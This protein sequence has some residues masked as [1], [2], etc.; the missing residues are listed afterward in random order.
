MLA[1]QAAGDAAKCMPTGNG[2]ASSKDVLVRPWGNPLPGAD[3]KAA[4]A[5]GFASKLRL[6]RAVPVILFAALLTTAMAGQAQAAP[7]QTQ[8]ATVPATSGAGQA[9]GLLGLPPSNDPGVQKAQQLLEKMVAAL[10][11]QAYLNIQDMQQQGRTYSFYHGEPEGTGAPFWRFWK[12]PDKDRLELTKQRDWV[13]VFNG[14]KGYETTFR[15][16]APV[17]AEQLDDY[18]RRR[19]HS[20]AWVLRKWL[21]QPGVA[22]FYEGPG[23]AE[24][25]QAE[26]VSVMTVDNDA[27]TIS[28]DS[29]TFLPLRVAFTWRDPKTR[30]RNDEAEGYDNYRPIQGVMSPF[31]IIRYH[32][33]EPANQR[34]INMVS[35]NQNLPDSQFAAKVTWDPNKAPTK[36][37]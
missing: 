8:S 28:I 10:G 11:G 37:K 29:N 3:K 34:F 25:K 4:K 17:E 5:R 27:A 35:Y 30:D 20:L 6:M 14:D 7:S 31:S 23:V 12:W 9:R 21:K 1:E 19:N 26:Q 13:I 15:G 2:S 18:L 36:K 33:G 24:R 32:N 16:T 22:L